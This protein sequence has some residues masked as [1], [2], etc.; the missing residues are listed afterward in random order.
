MNFLSIKDK[1]IVVVG[2][3]ILDE[4][5]YGNI[6]RISP[7]APVPV[8]RMQ[9]K[10]Y[11]LGGAANVA[12][13]L[14]ELGCQVKLVGMI[15][16]DSA[17]QKIITM[18]SKAGITHELI[19]TAQPTICKQRV[20]GN[21]LTQMI[22]LDYEETFAPQQQQY[23][24]EKFTLASQGANCCILSDYNKGTIIDSGALIK[25]AN[26]AGAKVLVDP[27]KDSLA[28][29]SGADLIT[30]NQQE[31][32][33][34]FQE[35]YSEL[36]FIQQQM[37]KNNIGA[38]LHTQGSRGMSL[39]KASGVTQKIAATA[40][41]VFDVTGAGDTVIAVMAAS[42]ALAMPLEL[43]MAYANYAA[44][45]VVRKQGIAS[46]TLSQLC[47]YNNSVSLE[48]SMIVND[49]TT[50]KT[51]GAKIVFTN[52]C[53]D[54]LHAGHISSLTAAKKLGDMLIVAVNSDQSIS[55]LK[56]ANRPIV[57]LADRVKLLQAL[58]VVDAV[59]VFSDAT[60]YNLIKTIQPDVLVKG[61]DYQVENVVGADFVKSYGGEVVLLPLTTGLSTSNII[62]KILDT[63]SLVS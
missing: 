14:R 16:A 47:Q 33:N 36:E 23:L 44:G 4:Y 52:G 1:Y 55:K 51:A 49:I 19:T 34:I 42:L 58:A 24:L 60:P 22:R 6:E 59:L 62:N 21:N 30:P 25:I 10:D 56:G 63:E 40:T 8:V 9:K 11:K 18:L 48:Q 7:E 38:I 12:F 39:L 17:A 15:G 3:I 13:N 26:Q 50:A 54:I 57:K 20:I 5:L 27:K 53:F 28:K 29:Y 41:E 43:A 61:A 45:I 32:K 31:F 2:D 37:K 46:I 35:R